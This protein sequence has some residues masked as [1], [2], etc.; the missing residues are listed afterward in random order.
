N[1][2]GYSLAFYYMELVPTAR[3]ETESLK[4][5]SFSPPVGIARGGFSAPAASGGACTF[6][7]ATAVG[8]YITY[9]VP[10]AKPGTFQVRVGTQSRSNKGI[11]QLSIN[12]A[13]QGFTVDEYS[14]SL[15]YGV[16]DLGTI[17]FLNTGDQNFTFTVK[18]K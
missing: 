5:Q 4:V 11:F 6:F 10:V 2:G 15:T 18:G 7:N 1:S 9:T 12:G 3:L 17:T 14:P 16:V 8:N 13:N